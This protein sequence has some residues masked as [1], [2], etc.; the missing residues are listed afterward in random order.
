MSGNLSNRE[1]TVLESN[2]NISSV[3]NE[4]CRP[5]LESFDI[6]FFLMLKLLMI[7]S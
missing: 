2:H 1:R 6:R 5:L 7:M 3:L 4:L